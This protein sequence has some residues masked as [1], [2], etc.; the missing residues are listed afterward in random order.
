MKFTIEVQKVY[1]GMEPRTKNKE[2]KNTIAI[3]ERRGQEQRGRQW[4]L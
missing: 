2:T 4:V 3:E 1:R